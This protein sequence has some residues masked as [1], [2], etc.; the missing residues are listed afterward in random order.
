MIKNYYDSINIK[1]KY[2]YPQLF[3]IKFLS[4]LNF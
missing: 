2:K 4:K 1:L 3:K